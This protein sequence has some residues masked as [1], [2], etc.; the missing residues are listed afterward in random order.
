MGSKID[1]RVQKRTRETQNADTALRQSG[2]TLVAAL[3]AAQH[4]QRIA[5]QLIN[6]RGTE[7]LYEQILDAA[8]AIMHSD[9]A[10]IQTFHAEPGTHGK[11][12]LLGYRGFS[13]QVAKRW[14]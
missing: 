13:P 14:E 11:L 3:E 4:L 5:N 6:A 1:K 8:L 12:K 7:A 9:Y 2:P 10:S